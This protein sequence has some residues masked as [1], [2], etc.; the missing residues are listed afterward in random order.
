MEI[1]AVPAVKKY[2]DALE[3]RAMAQYAMAVQA[4]K[5][6][7]DL[8]LEVECP[9][10]VDLADRTE[11]IIGPP[12]VGKRYRELYAEFKGD[13]TRA[14]FRLFKEIIEG[15]IG[16]IPNEEKRLEQ[17]VKTCLVLVTEGVVVAPLDGVPKVLISKNPDGSR[18]V[19]IYF[20]G[21]IRAAGGTATVFPLILGD[22]ARQLMG[23][24]RYRPTMDEIE[25]YVEEINIYDEII[26]RQFKLKDDEVRK[27]VQGCPVC[28]N[29]E[30][31]EEREVTTYKDLG[32]I[33]SNRIRGGMCLVIS[34][35]VGLKAMKIMSLAKM[36]GLNWDWLE[37]IIKV[38]K[39]STG[40]E[41]EVQPN[42]SYLSRI[43]AG[44]P[45]FSYPSVYGGFR[46][47]YGRARNTCIMGKGVHPATMHIL[48]DFVAVG[49]QA[50]M[51]RPGKSAEFFPVDSIEGPIVKLIGG[52]VRKIS[53]A[54]EAL[55]V[56]A[57]VEKIL[58]LGDCLI[59][60]GDFRKTAHPL[61]PAGYCEEWWKLEL[62]KEAKGNMLGEFDVGGFMKA[63]NLI[64]ENTAL[65]LALR[66]NVPLHPKYLHYY[67]A[68]NS[69]EAA[70]LVKEVRRAQKTFE[71]TEITE[72]LLE[73]KP[74]TKEMLEKI[75]LPHKVK[76]GK[77]V[78]EMDCAYS[79]FK[80]FGGTSQ[81]EPNTE[82]GVIGML[83]ALSGMKI[84]DK[85]GT[86]IG[87]RM[88]R[89]EAAKPRKMAG[90]PHTLF[91][92]GEYSG[93][94]R[95]INKA[96]EKF[97]NIEVEIA[98][99]SNPANGKVECQPFSMETG[100]RNILSRNQKDNSVKF[101]KRKINIEEL[102]FHGARSLNMNVPV[103][104]K[105]VKGLIN[106][107][108]LPEP[109]EKGILR[110]HHDLHIFRDGTIR[111]ELLNAPLTHFKPAEIGLGIE[112]A[113]ELGYTHD[114]EGREL[115]STG[116]ICEIF[117]QDIIPN[118]T[119]GDFY[120][121]VTKFVDDELERF[122]GLGKYYNFT[123]K[124]NLIGELFLGLAP[125]TSAGVMCRIIGFTKARVNFAH[126]YFHLAKR[127]N[128]DGDQDSI[129]LL[130]DV[131]LN[132]S[133]KYL[134]SSRGGRMD[135]PLVFSIAINPTEIDDEV[136]DVETCREYP[137]EL[138]EKS[139]SL[140]EPE[141]DSIPIIK[142]KLGKEGQYTGFGYTHET[143]IFDA[144]P[145]KSTYV[146]LQSM[147][148]KMNAQAALQGKI[149]AVDQKDA[150]E[151]V[152]ASHFLPDII[153]NTRSFSRQ[154]FRCSKCNAKYRRVPLTGKCAKCNEETLILTIAQG[155]VRKY[156]NIAKNMISTYQLSPYLK[157]RI[158]LIEKEIDSVFMNEKVQQK[159]LF[160]YV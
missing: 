111:F 21:P 93:N 144:G 129:M 66:F 57:S 26:T 102:L 45:I 61:M 74:E 133:Q 24:D 16:D 62:Q 139:L 135:A 79:F 84:M 72:L 105:G 112:K 122:Y 1:K 100:K 10:T 156:L 104:V 11:N 94:T 141:I 76:Q 42:F 32:R 49:T 86:F 13:R 110:A 108:K 99:F 103:L 92:I 29:G 128:A 73:K 18:Y 4:R 131:L 160:E 20:A 80:T 137:L 96:A 140:S 30:P 116:Q 106:S 142:K 7:K 89:P 8:S 107:D 27:I 50:K 71:G 101:S 109:I 69:E 36:L 146:E 33:P 75:G 23:L 12:G 64:D 38:S 67:T 138:Y 55:K 82:A 154:V 127:R 65:E 120:L 15:E 91:P 132:F 114:F 95:S 51:E 59:A 40:N 22:Y 113:R 151:R 158:D 54:E 134:P 5:K 81:D 47:R 121:R 70:H 155:S 90:D 117:P 41:K 35:G 14:I 17:A 159:S 31:T 43:A 3:K 25:R 157:Q 56:R 19:D 83:C 136:Y 125:H 152:L 39:G 87:C 52:E 97:Q 48:D 150:L 34:E 85:A 153:G 6:G 124:D 148:D 149:R 9:P 118:E 68:L 2:F 37:S 78:V 119:A 77:I 46:L 126:P 115:V 145:K 143:S 58:F 98:E 123:S 63:P 44:R 60:L 88:G 130:M 28:V 53:S 147:E